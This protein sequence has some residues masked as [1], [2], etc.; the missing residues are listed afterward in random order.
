MR[1]GS[2][3]RLRPILMTALVTSV[4]FVP[5]ALAHVAGAEVQRPLAVV[6]IGGL[7]TSTFLM[8]CCRSFTSGRRK[9]RQPDIRNTVTIHTRQSEWPTTYEIVLTRKVAT[10]PAES[11]YN[12]EY[13]DT[14]SRI[15]CISTPL[16]LK[17]YLRQKIHLAESAAKV[18]LLDEIA[19]P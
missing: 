12:R 17:N 16:W 13:A 2:L 10:F 6:V 19:A 8:F 3:L 5:M 4:G 9:K 1:E 11:M 18:Y 15:L 7:L 14:R